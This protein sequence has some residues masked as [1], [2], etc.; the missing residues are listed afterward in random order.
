[1]GGPEET[2]V[3]KIPAI[4]STITKIARRTRW[5]VQVTA[6]SKVILFV[7]GPVERDREKRLAFWNGTAASAP[8]ATDDTAAP[9]NGDRKR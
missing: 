6:L 7:N 1:M 3:Y 9:T 4:G 2:I 8:I 5:E